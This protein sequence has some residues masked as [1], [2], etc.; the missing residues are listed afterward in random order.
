MEMHKGGHNCEI[1]MQGDKQGKT[2]LK[3]LEKAIAQLGFRKAV[4]KDSRGRPY[5]VYARDGR[6][7][8]FSALE[9]RGQY[10]GTTSAFIM[11]RE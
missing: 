9:R 8:T 1:L 11:Y 5:E 7:F 2:T 10:G 3:A 4:A 6:A